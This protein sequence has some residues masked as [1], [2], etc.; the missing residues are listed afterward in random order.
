[1]R[2]FAKPLSLEKRL[3]LTVELRAFRS[4]KATQKHPKLLHFTRECTH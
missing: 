4:T 1:M 2:R 3:K